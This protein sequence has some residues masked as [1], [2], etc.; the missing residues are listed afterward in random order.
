MGR[1]ERREYIDNGPAL[2]TATRIERWGRLLTVTELADLITTSTKQ[3]YALVEKK[4]VPS[5]RIAG[6]IRFEPVAVA[7]WLRSQAV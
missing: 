3:V 1:T 2:D 4:Y 6:S 5:L 7:N